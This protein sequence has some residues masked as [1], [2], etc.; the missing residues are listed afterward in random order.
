MSPVLEQ[1][2]DRLVTLCEALPEVVTTSGG[3][4]HLGFRVRNRAF[5]WYLDDH[6]GDGMI[7]L[8]A[9]TTPLMQA[10]LVADAPDRYSLPAYV[11]RYGWVSLRIDQRT[12]DW[13]EVSA[14]VRGSY[15]LVAPKRLAAQVTDPE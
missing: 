8:S 15:R 13:D 14:L 11:A 3:G 5:A 7:V 12:I 1:R 6:H 9:R 10:A 4:R 2:R